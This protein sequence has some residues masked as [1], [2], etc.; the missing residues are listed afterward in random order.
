MAIFLCSESALFGTLIGTYFY[1][2]FTSTEW[3]QGGIAAPSVA[4]PLA[5]TALLV[6]SCAPI[7][8]AVRAAAAGRVRAAWWLVALA[9]L[10]QAAYLGG[11]IASYVHDLGDFGPSTNA[12]GS[13]YFTLLGAHH[14]HV[15]A[16]LLL[17]GW[18][19]GRLTGG[20]TS[21]RLTAVRAIALYWYVVAALAVAVVA[22]QVSPA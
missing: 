4:L 11:Q 7:A 19:L 2:Q 20:V 9:A 3:P 21:Y 12:Y 16:G 22:T 6:V 8:G 14:L 10:L 13:I 1:L 15:I 5:L 17:S 18:L